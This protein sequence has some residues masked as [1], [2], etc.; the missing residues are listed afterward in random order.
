MTRM[1]KTADPTIVP[2]PRSPLVMKTPDMNRTVYQ[3]LINTVKLIEKHC[4]MSLTNQRCEKLRG[5]ASCCHK[6]GT[7]NI[8]TEVQILKIQTSAQNML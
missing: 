1:L 8:F 7:G 6:G 2:T 4:K 5:G 3:W